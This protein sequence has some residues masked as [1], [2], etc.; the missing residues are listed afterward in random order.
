MHE[1]GHS[2]GLNEFNTDQYRILPINEDPINVMR[3][4]K[5]SFTGI[6]PC[7]RLVYLYKWGDY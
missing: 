6:G 2:L 4:G 7:D 1:I 5:R 3:Q